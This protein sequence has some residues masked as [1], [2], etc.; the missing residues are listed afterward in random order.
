ML[1]QTQLRL[2]LSSQ[3]VLIYVVATE[4]ERLEYLINYLAQK[5]LKSSIYLWNFIDGYH[6]NPNYLNQAV[7]NPVQALEFIEKISPAGPAIFFLKDF[8][9]FMSDIAVI[10]KI[11]N[12]SRYLRQNNL[13]IIISSP[14]LSIPSSLR[15]FLTVVEFPLPNANEIKM[16]LTR[17]FQVLSIDSSSLSLNDLVLAYRG[18]SV[19]R[20]RRSI[21][22][23]INN[24]TS[25]DYSAMTS[26][27]LEKQQL[28]RQTDILDFCSTSSSL[29]DI[30]GLVFLK[31]WLKKRSSAFSQQAKNYGLPFPRGILLMGIQGTGKSLIAKS[32]ASQW[33]LPL[34]K[35]DIG[36]VFAGIVGESE[37]RMRQAIKISEQ[38]SPCILWIDEIDKVFTRP[39]SSVDS[40]TTSRVLSTFLT[41]LADKDQAVFVVAT[42]NQLLS[43]PSEL[44]R[45]GRFDEIFFLNLPDLQEREKIFQIHLEKFRPLSWPKYDIKHLSILT[46]SFSGAEIRQV[47][48]EA[49]YNAF[50][51]K[52]EFST[53]D[54]ID[55]IDNFIPLFFT[56]QEAML[57][58]Q[59]WA[60]SGSIRLAS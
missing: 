56:D 29:D 43:L 34:L 28:I 47:I 5:H 6:N 15:D 37:K 32:I 9:F 51:A 54:I 44:L 24:Y 49:M 52:R 10:R 26:I 21:A 31:D 11:K 20:I 39:S 53:Q 41:W 3:H 40:G 4:E 23:L 59:K 50:Y 55:V 2:L 8:H 45:K 36:K 46:D 14:E 57:R 16:E 19:E 48:V 38:S 25:L 27:M 33:K 12:V 35:L 18:F 60:M 42:A 30:G 17:L 1:F 7:R 22:K 13:S 58:M